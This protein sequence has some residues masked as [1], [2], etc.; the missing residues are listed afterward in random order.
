MEDEDDP[1]TQDEY[2]KDAVIRCR[3]LIIH[4]SDYQFDIGEWAHNI[5]TRYGE[6]TFYQFAAE[7]GID[8][9]TLRAYR[10]TYRKWKDQ[11]AHP[12]SFSVARALNMHPQKYEIW[13]E[14]RKERTELDEIL[15]RD[16]MSVGQAKR[17]MKRWREEQKDA[18][19]VPHKAVNQIY[20]KGDRW[21]PCIR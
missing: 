4:I 10:A 19:G 14:Y 13:Q 12:K 1:N 9:A 7:I 20:Y 8:V 11:P 2:Y 16:G 17:E 6:N 21:V 18:K 3:A 15:D 5:E